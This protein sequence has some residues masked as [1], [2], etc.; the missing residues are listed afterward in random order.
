MAREDGHFARPRFPFPI[1]TMVDFRLLLA[2]A[3]M[4]AALPAQSAMF[5]RFGKAC[6]YDTDRCLTKN[7]QYSTNTV[8]PPADRWIY[9]RLTV[10][11][12]QT[13]NVSGFEFLLRSV[14]AP[15][16]R[17]PTALHAADG[18]NAPGAKI[19][20]GTEVFVDSSQRWCSTWFAPRSFGPNT[21]L[22]LAYRNPGSMVS[23]GATADAAGADSQWYAGGVRQA[24]VKW[25]YRVLCNGATPNMST[26]P[27][28]SVPRVGRNFTL[29]CDNVPA[30][31]F[32]LLWFGVPSAR[33]PFD[34]TAAGAPQCDLNVFPA[35]VERVPGINRAANFSFVVP[36]LPGA[37]IHAQWAVAPHTSNPAGTSFSEGARMIF[38]S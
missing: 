12:G 6:R 23:L 28:G 8:Q 18:T 27:A 31:G 29:H 9:V 37:E 19:A 4:L 21:V 11:A 2:A 33:V 17:V 14:N 26:L 34:G 1:Q 13:L 7:T 24:N 5:S 10:P 25:K 22:Y 16:V 20:D 32:A 36:P 3:T 30:G 38:G 35:F 15:T